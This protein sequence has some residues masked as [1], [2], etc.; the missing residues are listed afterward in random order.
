MAL[1]LYSPTPASNSNPAE[2]VASIEHLLAKILSLLPLR[3]LLRFKSVSK[4]WLSLITNPIFTHLRNPNPNPPV[5]LFLPIAKRQSFDFEFIPFR[6]EQSINPPFTRLDFTEDPSGIKII[7]SCNGLLLC[8]SISEPNRRFYVCNPTA[9]AFRELPKP[10]IKVSNSIC[11]MSLAFNP[12]ESR[13][14]NV[15]CVW[16]LGVED[17]TNNA[18]FTIGV[19]SSRTD[20][21]RLRGEGFTALVNFER[22]VFWNGAINWMGVGN[23]ESL[24]FDVERHVFDK[25]PMLPLPYGWNSRSNYYFDES[26]DHLHFVE[27]RCPTIDFNVYEMKRDYSEWFVK[28]KVDLRPVVAANRDMILGRINPIGW[29]TFVFSVLA[30]VRGEREE[31]SFLVLQ[32]PSRS[33]RYN[34]VCKTFENLHE[35]EGNMVNGSLK[36]PSI[37][38]FQYIESLCCV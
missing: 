17:R 16:S 37:N 31:D 36:Y 24:Y 21:W 19:Y 26:C 38:G 32:T 18:Q 9:K 1:D 29:Y 13:Y 5:A 28:Y 3:S 25:M 4:H 7:Q 20:S 15:V 11:G 22:G 23:G 14:Y 33:I 34:L 12:V 2:I 35:F 6:A 10:G 27:M 30:V 8:C